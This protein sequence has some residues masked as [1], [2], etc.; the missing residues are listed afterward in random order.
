MFNWLKER[1]LQKQKIKFQQRVEDYK[2]KYQRNPEKPIKFGRNS[3]WFAIKNR[4]QI[5]CN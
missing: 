3:W 1:K 4:R 2:I 5:A